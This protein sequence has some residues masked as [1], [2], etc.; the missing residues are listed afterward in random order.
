M[1]RGIFRGFNPGEGVAL[2]DEGEAVPVLKKFILL[3]DAT[4]TIWSPNL[5]GPFSS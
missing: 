3:L 1:Y 2:I 4:V 5:G